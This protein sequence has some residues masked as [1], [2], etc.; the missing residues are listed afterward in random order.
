MKITDPFINTDPRW[1][2]FVLTPDEAAFCMP[3]DAARDLNSY[4]R[5]ASRTIPLASRP[6]EPDD[7][8]R[9]GHIHGSLN[10]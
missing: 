6:L 1:E 2:T 3:D 4:L 7:G 8:L 9:L 5:S 10:T